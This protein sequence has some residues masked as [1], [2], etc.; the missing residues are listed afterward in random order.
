[1]LEMACEK[2]RV[3]KYVPPFRAFSND[4]HG[5]A[6]NALFILGRIKEEGVCDDATF[7]L[8]MVRIC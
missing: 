7:Y 2:L 3:E 6:E 8:P 5:R 4:R 1:M